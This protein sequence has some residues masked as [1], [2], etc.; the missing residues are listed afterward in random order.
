MTCIQIET[1][2]LDKRKLALIFSHHPLGILRAYDPLELQVVKLGVRHPTRHLGLVDIDRLLARR[3]GQE[4]RRHEFG[5]EFS[6]LGQ[7]VKDDGLGSSQ[8]VSSMRTIQGQ[9]RA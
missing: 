7:G 6:M 1:D 3:R 9:T 8:S 2:S 5:V 4:G